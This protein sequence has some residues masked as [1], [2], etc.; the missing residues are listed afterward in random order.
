MQFIF[1]LENRQIVNIL[2]FFE[3]DINEIKN[4][5]KRITIF[6]MIIISL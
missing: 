5:V 6:W 1:K 2:K 3:L 4:L